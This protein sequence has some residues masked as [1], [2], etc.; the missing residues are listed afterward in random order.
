MRPAADPR[1]R[2][3]P[4][5]AIYP[6]TRLT[7]IVVS[8]VMACASLSKVVSVGARPD[9]GRDPHAE[10]FTLGIS[11]SRYVPLR[12]GNVRP[13]ARSV[14]LKLWTRQDLRHGIGGQI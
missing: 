2:A 7:G 8:C 13:Q 3:Q 4:L 6:L 10:G 11:T 9:R 1:Q 12:G 5:R 14:S